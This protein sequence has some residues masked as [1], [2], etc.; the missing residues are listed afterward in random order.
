MKKELQH[1]IKMALIYSF[2]GIL[3]QGLLVNMLLALPNNAQGFKS[4]KEVYLDVDFHSSPLT[5][6]FSVLEKKTSFSFG[7]DERHIDK[8]IRID[9]TAKN[10]S[11]ESV[12]IE[13]SKKTYLRFRQ[14]NNAIDVKLEN[15]KRENYPMVEIIQTRTITGRV[16][17]QDE[18]GGL[19]GVNVIEKGTSN[20]TVTNIEGV[21]SLQV[22]EGATL[23]F[24]S[25]GYT[26]EE[27]EIG[28]RSIIDLVLAPDIKQLEE[29]VVIGFGTQKK[30]NLTGA[31]A[32][33]QVDDKITSRSISTVSSAMSGLIPGLSVRQE[34]GM[35][36]NEGAELRI[37]GI[38]TPN[39][40][41][42]LIVV[43]GMPDVDI[44]RLNINDIESISVLKDA[45]SAAIY[46]SR[47]ANGVI[48]I[49]TKR[50]QSDQVVF[51][52]TGLSTWANE[53]QYYN[54]IPDYVFYMN[55]YN[56]SYQS[57]GK[58]PKFSTGTIDQWMAMGQIDPIRFA[59]T[60]WWNLFFKT[61]NVQNHNLS[62]SGG[63]E[64]LNFFL[65]G[66]FIT[67]DGLSINN[68]YNRM[69]LRL[70]LDYKVLDRVKIGTTI[71]GNNTKLTYPLS[72][73]IHD[74]TSTGEYYRLVPGIAPVDEQ[75][76]LGGPMA[77]REET[78]AT[79][80]IEQYKTYHRIL[81]Q[82][83]AVFNLYGQ[84]EPAKGLSLRVDYGVDYFNGF[85]K[86]Y[87]DPIIRWNLQTEEPLNEINNYGG[88][89]NRFDNNY[90]TLLQNRIVYTTD[91]FEGHTFTAM[92]VYTE[93]F[94]STRFLSGSR[95]Y[96][97]NPSLSELAGAT[98]EIVN[99]NGN[100]SS[101][102][103]RSGIGRLNYN[104]K[105]KYLFETNIRAD[106]SSKFSKGNRL[107]IFPSFSAGWRFSQEGFFKPL[108][109]IISSA[110]IRV[111]YGELG[112]NSGIGRYEQ[113]ETFL[114]TNY[115]LGQN[116]VTGVANNQLLNPDLTWEHTSVKNIGLDLILNKLSAEL[117]VYERLTSDI[118]RPSEIPLIL[119]ETYLAP[120]TNIGELRNRGFEA[121][122]GYNDN[123]GKFQY[124]VQFN[125]SFNRNKLLSWN[126]RLGY[127]DT[128]LDYPISYARA[129]I[130]RGIA[131]TYEDIM[132]APYQGNQ[133]FS[134]GDLLFEDLNGDGQITGDD[135]GV[136]RN[137]PRNYF[138]SHYGLGFD[139]RWKN[140]D[141]NF[142][143][144]ASTGSKDFWLDNFNSTQIANTTWHFYEPH[145]NAWSYDNPNSTTMPRLTNVD[146]ATMNEARSTFW[147]YKRNY[148]RLKN[149]QIGYNLP[150]SLLSK[151]NIGNLR[152]YVTGENLLTLTNWPGIDPEKS[153]G[154]S[155]TAFDAY[156]QRRSLSL[157]I[158][159]D[160]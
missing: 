85:R 86:S 143:F 40:S 48:L 16:T 132:N 51:K 94:W 128:F 30:V 90:K 89:T 112:N 38:G 24:S 126:E 88:I 76:R 135:M 118:I 55:S 70:N 47:A 61:G 2:S 142:L 32:S 58:V 130:T 14:V 139:A 23:V 115:M 152:L 78:I 3:I 97:L 25:V 133:Y 158:N 22:S 31:V 18:S 124:N 34:S 145:L 108:I 137:S 10:V 67:D 138:N 68:T 64:K 159:I 103:L 49:T 125:Y 93:E 96:R 102:G 109:G 20:G 117:D 57:S 26:R 17:S 81:S 46:G 84:W 121:N 15:R 113:R 107:G 151:V 114:L 127:G 54:Y 91:L 149:A 150:K 140:F 129:Y 13:I 71:G 131:Q 69:N 45:A 27:V 66:G 157:G 28:N 43:D 79:N 134:P 6:V 87:N 39:N 77:Y 83:Q 116:L 50:G 73:G 63:T 144:M 122:L 123:I 92:A 1:L 155:N 156:P 9:L 101:E 21:Y 110:K 82:Q 119:R 106:E 111:S 33:V 80:L 41:N 36:G 5:E 154:N 147:L 99:A 19:P 104:I 95:S 160:F 74:G 75:G 29:L 98:P 11:L 35:A 153:K 105:D 44:N 4:V 120:R 65:S 62:A 59:N 53:A 100:T 8:N 148:L 146:Q 52:Y 42:P 37:R 12:L 60:D 72:E 56:R 136:F 7:Y 141:L